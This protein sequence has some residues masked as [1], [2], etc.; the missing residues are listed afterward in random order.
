MDL[1]FPDELVLKQL[2][3]KYLTL[4]QYIYDKDKDVI[5]Y[6]NLDALRLINT[7][8]V[9]KDI[10]H[11]LKVRI[12]NIIYFSILDERQ[13]SEFYR[14]YV[15][16]LT[17]EYNMIRFIDVILGSTSFKEMI[18]EIIN[19]SKE[20]IKNRKVNILGNNHVLTQN[21]YVINLDTGYS[22][23]KQKD[24]IVSILLR[25]DLDYESDINNIKHLTEEFVIFYKKL[26]Y[27]IL[28]GDNII[29]VIY[30]SPQEYIHM[31]LML[32]YIFCALFL[33]SDARD[34][35]K[36]TLCL[37]FLNRK[38]VYI[39]ERDDEI[40]IGIEIQ[41]YTEIYLPTYNEALKNNTE[42][43]M[44]DMCIIFN[45]CLREKTMLSAS[46]IFVNISKY[47]SW[48]C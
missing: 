42:H 4:E 19:D 35:S 1:K 21:G 34:P 45:E 47:A 10:D 48:A 2:I 33:G 7:Y 46:D 9:V 14:I 13:R 15:I 18:T 36:T 38:L 41:E 32:R 8:N 29:V 3:L 23:K 27:E 30:N 16:T 17:Y 26:I 24:D 6:E 20:K 5:H 31:E 25:I 12:Y 37:K 11:N 39:S 22:W 28:F 43:G 44:S 40:P